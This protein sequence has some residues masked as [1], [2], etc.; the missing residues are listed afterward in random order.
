MHKIFLPPFEHP[1]IYQAHV[2]RV[3]TK[4]SQIRYL[5][6]KKKQKRTWS[7]LETWL[8]FGWNNVKFMI[9]LRPYFFS[10][11]NSTC[12]ENFNLQSI[13]SPHIINIIQLKSNHWIQKCWRNFNFYR[14]F[15]KFKCKPL[16]KLKQSNSYAIIL[17]MQSLQNELIEHLIELFQILYYFVSLIPNLDSL[18]TKDWT[19]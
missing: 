19:L 7:C 12:Y 17:I 2:L 9:F 11:M 6:T 4:K 16:K 10:R 8:E 14:I 5:H 13:F 15:T 3:A 1:A 18:V